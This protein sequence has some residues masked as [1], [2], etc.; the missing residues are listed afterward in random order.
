MRLH[1]SPLAGRF[2]QPWQPQQ[3]TPDLPH[4]PPCGSRGQASTAPAANSTPIWP[5]DSLASHD[6]PPETVICIF[7][8]SL[9]RRSVS[10]LSVSSSTRRDLQPLVGV[11]YFSS[12][13]VRSPECAPPIPRWPTPE[14][15]STTAIVMR[16]ESLPQGRWSRPVRF[17]Q[18]PPNHR[19]HHPLPSSESQY[20]C[21]L[22]LVQARVCSRPHPRPC[23]HPLPPF[24]DRLVRRPLSTPGPSEPTPS[25]CHRP[26]PG[27]PR[28]RRSWPPTAPPTSKEI[29]QAMLRRSA[30]R[31][32]RPAEQHPRR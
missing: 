14:P 11:Y 12:R 4:S 13:S 19:S 21:R 16:A 10:F 17:L 18:E 5:R 30:G 23:R 32:H 31:S 8:Q 26:A 2:V 1:S 9:S 25:A 20:V 15:C 3:Q 28:S 27:R 22:N 7:I 24:P 29:T 6:P